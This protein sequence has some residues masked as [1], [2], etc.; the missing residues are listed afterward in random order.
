VME[1]PKCKGEGFL[2]VEDIE[3]VIKE[4]SIC[5][6]EGW[7]KSRLKAIK[8]SHEFGK[9]EGWEITTLSDD[10]D[11][12]IEQAEKVERLERV[13]LVKVALENKGFKIMSI[14]EY[15]NEGK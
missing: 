7:M 5:K 9:G 12:L 15:E 10:I 4:C 11:W 3:Y 13:N 1:C 2:V 6:G 8:D 14:G